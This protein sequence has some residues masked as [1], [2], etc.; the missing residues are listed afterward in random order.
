M[1]FL[2]G[3]E[4]VQLR[5]AG[6][7]VL[8]DLL[9]VEGAGVDIV[10]LVASG[11][12]VQE[13]WIGQPYV[14]QGHVLHCNSMFVIGC[15]EAIVKFPHFTSEM[16]TSKGKIDILP[17]PVNAPAAVIHSRRYILQQV[18]PQNAEA[19]GK[20][21]L[22]LEIDMLISLLLGYLL[23]FVGEL[24]AGRLV[25]GIGCAFEL[26]FGREVVIQVHWLIFARFRDC[27]NHRAEQVNF[28]RFGAAVVAAQA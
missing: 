7:V 25:E 14:V 10:E 5:L 16:T 11:L 9:V 24:L 12:V 19:K 22:L 1:L 6:E 2:G 27:H 28:V 21:E 3:F 17:R 15:I 23:A 20:L 4:A 8:I 26:G 13:G 18:Q